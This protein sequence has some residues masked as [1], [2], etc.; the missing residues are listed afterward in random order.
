MTHEIPKRNP[1]RVDLKICPDGK[2]V[3][4]KFWLTDGRYRP[5]R[6]EVKETS[7][8]RFQVRGAL[9][10]LKDHGYEV[11]RW[12]GTDDPNYPMLWPGARAMKEVGPIRSRWEIYQLRQRVEGK[13]GSSW[14]IIRTPRRRGGSITTWHTTSRQL[15]DQGNHHA[16]NDE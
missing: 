4:K 8:G 6:A 10:W 15:S 7:G 11:I 16:R 14:A 3:V 13:C 5:L 1:E 2:V 12:A 9:K